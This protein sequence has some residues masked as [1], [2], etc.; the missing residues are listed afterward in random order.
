M[1]VNE[2]LNKADEDENEVEKEIQYEED[3]YDGSILV[4]IIEEEEDKEGSPD[5]QQGNST[6]FQAASQIANTIMGAG[7]L[8]IPVFYKS[9]GII[10]GT[11][12]MLVSAWGTIYSV[13]CLLFAHRVTQKSGYSIFSKICY[14]NTGNLVVKIAIVAN[15][16]GVTC[17]YMRIFGDVVG[18]V[19][20]AFV[21]EDNFFSD[22]WHNFIY[23]L[24][25]AGISTLFIFKEEIDSLKHAS[26]V[27]I[28][29]IGILFTCIIILYGYKKGEGLTYEFDSEMLYPHGEFYKM[30][31]TI[32]T[33]I[34]AFGFQF[35][36][37]PIYYSMKEPTPENFMKAIYMAMGFC[38]FVYT[39]VGVLAYMTYGD[40]MRG[41]SILDS[42]LD[43]MKLNKDGDK[44]ILVLL[45]IICISFLI[46]ATLSIPLCFIGMKKN[47]LNSVIFC[48][49]KYC[50]T[51]ATE[52]LIKDSHMYDDLLH[53]QGA[54]LSSVNHPPVS[55]ENYRD[56]RKPSGVSMKS[57]RSI[58][59]S[60]K[61]SLKSK[62]ELT[63]AIQSK[64]MSNTEKNSIIIGVYIFIVVL[65]IMVTKLSTFFNLIGATCSNSISFIFPNLF[66]IKLSEI[67]KI[68]S[69]R[70]GLPWVIFILGFVL[71]AIC[72]TGEVL[73]NI[74]DED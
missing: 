31:A 24:I 35:N 47:L 11:L 38:C 29:A 15:N 8:A 68:R 43:D 62:K 57:I 16:F 32:P 1:I 72:I 22:N 13:Y 60:R 3:E 10:V 12:L 5:D 56:S 4:N 26:V 63:V 36:V 25:I 53:D 39:V 20:G 64:Y 70:L 55:Y 44:F 30:L 65:T 14:G 73:N 49:K 74:K 58:K 21:T 50:K 52:E 61:F 17:A 6:V 71:M 54:A 19:V 40:D 46:V 34:L 41:G 42:L 33:I 9:Y 23:I 51:K 66:V 59:S 18:G 28:A 37:F 2:K 45:L 67:L 69:K 48:K 27:S 7:I